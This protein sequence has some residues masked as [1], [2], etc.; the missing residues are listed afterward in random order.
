[1]E[2]NPNLVAYLLLMIVV[3][4][5]AIASPVISGDMIFSFT[6]LFSVPMIVASVVEI[7]SSLFLDK[8]RKTNLTLSMVV[9]PLVAGIV[10]YFFTRKRIDNSEAS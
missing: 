8:R 6:Y 5:L 7:N 4:I 3:D 10:Y 9:F 1:M 2:K